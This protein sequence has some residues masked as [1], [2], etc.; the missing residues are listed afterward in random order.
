[1]RVC[2]VDWL[3]ARLDALGMALDWLEQWMAKPKAE[4]DTLDIA[5]KRLVP[6]SWTGDSAEAFA[7]HWASSTKPAIEGLPGAVGQ[8]HKIL[9]HLYDDLLK[10]QREAED[11][12]D[13]ARAQG[14]AV[15]RSGVP[16]QL[17]NGQGGQGISPNSPLWNYL[18]ALSRCQEAVGALRLD[19]CR[20]LS[21][22]H[23]YFQGV[24]FNPS[25]ATTVDTWLGMGLEAMERTAEGFAIV[26]T[27][28]TTMVRLQVETSVFEATGVLLRSDDA[29]LVLKMVEIDSSASLRVTQTVTQD[30]TKLSDLKAVKAIPIIGYGLIGLN[31]FLD[32]QADTGAGM[33]P[34]LALA[35][36]GAKELGSTGAGMLAGSAAAAGATMLFGTSAP[37][38]LVAGP[39]LIAAA[40]VAD[41]VGHFVDDLFEENW[42]D[43][44]GDPGALLGDVAH[45]GGKAIDETLNDI[46]GVGNAILGT[47]G[48]HVDIKLW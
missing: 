23:G 42:G 21:Q 3:N 22:L 1:M 7:R 36:A 46:G 41:G 29:A 26:D 31:M 9:E 14:V 37:F 11:E 8:L 43:D 33:N 44:M 6:G 16:D 10:N 48:L 20:R 4:S 47:V 2:H 19:A 17:R 30:V 39:E 38:L 40:I 32:Y 28:V 24:P 34:A 5:V 12:A 25:D 45:S 35:K 27:T 18:E 13:K 15:D